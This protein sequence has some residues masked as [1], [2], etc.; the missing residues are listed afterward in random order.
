[1][2]LVGLEYASTTFGKVSVLENASICKC[3]HNKNN[4]ILGRTVELWGGLVRGT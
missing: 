4:R 2:I 3:P 1:M